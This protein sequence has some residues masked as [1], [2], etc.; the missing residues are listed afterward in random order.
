MNKREQLKNI[1]DS[2]RNKRNL[3]KLTDVF[4][5]EKKKYSLRTQ[6]DKERIYSL[7]LMILLSLGMIIITI[8]MVLLGIRF[9][10]LE[11]DFIL[12]VIGLDVF[13]CILLIYTYLEVCKQ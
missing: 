10:Y 11:T 5:S 12:Y 1:L 13:F 2:H 6:G 4:L 8:L 3:E 7:G 9:N